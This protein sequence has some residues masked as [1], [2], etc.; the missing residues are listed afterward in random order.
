MTKSRRDRLDDDPARKWLAQH[1]PK[2]ASKPKQKPQQPERWEMR[3]D[4]QKQE[5]RALAKP[6]LKYVE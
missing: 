2:Q 1:A 6:L 5:R 4:Q 3:R